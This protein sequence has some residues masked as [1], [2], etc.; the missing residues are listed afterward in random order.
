MDVDSW[1]QNGR[2]SMVAA[3]SA[4]GARMTQDMHGAMGRGGTGV[5]G[6]MLRAC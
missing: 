5:A 1:F 6:G 3:C 2:P 4:D